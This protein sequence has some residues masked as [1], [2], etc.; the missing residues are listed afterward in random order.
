MKR[1]AVL[2]LCFFVLTQL[3]N[4]QTITDY[5]N[6]VYNTVT[7][8]TQVW[9]KENLKTKHFNNGD[10]L[11]TTYPSTLSISGI[12]NPKY[13]WPCNGSEDSVVKYGRLYTWYTISDTRGVCPSGWHIPTETEFM[14]LDTFMNSNYNIFPSTPSYT[15]AL[16]DL[17]GWNALDSN[18]YPGAP[19]SLDYPQLRNISGFSGRA[20]GHREYNGQFVYTTL[21]QKAAFWSFTNYNSTNAMR[22]YYMN[23]AYCSDA[24]GPDAKKYG[25]SVRC[26]KD[27]IPNH[28]D[29]NN[30]NLF[31]IYPNPT[32]NNLTIEGIANTLVEIV[33]LN[34]KIIKTINVLTTK[35]L[36]D[37]S[38]LNNGIYIIKAKSEKNIIV[39]KIIKQ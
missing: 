10:S 29:E 39:K 9:M 31:N 16:S 15:K 34:G 11:G 6:N 38:Q 23:N 1:E 8:N 20:A 26:I 22:F 24:I 27:A 4:S 2:L 7:I 21:G 37:L 28:L 33:D 17:I 35:V 18:T 14:I 5:D 36:I 3:C 25:F 19:G 12:S 30:K 13:Q 32:F